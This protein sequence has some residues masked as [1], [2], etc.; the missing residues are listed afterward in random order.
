MNVEEGERRS[1]G[2][3]ETGAENAR[4][5]GKEAIAV[6]QVK[7]T[8]GEGSIERRRNLGKGVNQKKMKNK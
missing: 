5:R 3:I 2:S 1:Q 7:R 6:I 8:E 4:R